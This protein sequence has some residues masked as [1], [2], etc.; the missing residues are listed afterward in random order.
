[1]EEQCRN[2]QPEREEDGPRGNVEVQ[3]SRGSKQDEVDDQR[4]DMVQDRGPGEDVWHQEP[5][6]RIARDS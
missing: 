4:E 2:G 3:V 6:F 1:M 5:P